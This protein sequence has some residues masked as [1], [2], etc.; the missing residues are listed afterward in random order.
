MMDIETLERE[1]ER[2][3]NFYSAVKAIT[4][5]QLS[6]F[7]PVSKRAH[8]ESLIRLERL[9]KQLREQLDACKSGGAH[10]KLE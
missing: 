8:H 6:R 10:E 4:P 7:H 3:R 1:L 9:G 5:A 2:T